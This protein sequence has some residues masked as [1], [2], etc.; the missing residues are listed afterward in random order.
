M[1]YAEIMTHKWAISMAAFIAVTC[2]VESCGG[3]KYY[4]V[5]VWRFQNAAT[6]RFNSIV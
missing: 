6:I 3:A 4:V 1:K 5:A 2:T